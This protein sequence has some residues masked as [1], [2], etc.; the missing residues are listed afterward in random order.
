MPALGGRAAHQR[1]T[2]NI[3]AVA[4]AD[5]KVKD[6]AGAIAKVLDRL[7]STLVTALQQPA[8]TPHHPPAAS[9]DGAPPT[10]AHHSAAGHSAPF[11]GGGG[12]GQHEALNRAV[13]ALAVC[14]KYVTDASPPDSGV[15]LGFLPVNRSDAWGRADASLFSFLVR[16]MWRHAWDVGGCVP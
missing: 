8:T 3:H 9:F 2:T 13:K 10:P 6:A 12:W 15:E 11:A 14:R 4:Q 16:G 5:T 7:C 1:R